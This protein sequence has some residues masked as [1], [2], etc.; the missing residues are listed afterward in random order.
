MEPISDA[1]KGKIFEVVLV[2]S[3]FACSVVNNVF[4]KT[5]KGQILNVTECR[6]AVPIMCTDSCSGTNI[7]Y[8]VMTIV[9]LVAQL[10]SD[11]AD[12]R[13]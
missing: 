9:N 7:L 8:F 5:T 3:R 12:T 13:V 11:V 2:G 1:A 6:I 10:W 4:N